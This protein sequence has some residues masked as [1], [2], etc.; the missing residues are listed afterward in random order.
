VAPFKEPNGE[1]CYWSRRQRLALAALCAVLDVLPADVAQ[2]AEYAQTFKEMAEALRKVQRP[3]GFWNVSLHDPTDFGGKEVTGTAL[4]PTVWPG[5]SGKASC[6]RRS[7]DRWFVKAWNAMAG[8]AVASGRKARL[9]AGNRSPA[10]G[11]ATGHLRQEPNFEDFGLGC[12]LLAG[13]KCTKL[14][15]MAKPASR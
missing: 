9:C 3:D 2:R 7:T 11:L 6:R 15:T 8:E 13:A 12:F 14:A 1:D 10:E 5:A 4:S